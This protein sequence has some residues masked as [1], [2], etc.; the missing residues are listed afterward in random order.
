[1]AAYDL[2]LTNPKELVLD[3]NHAA[4]WRHSLLTTHM[5]IVMYIR[6]HS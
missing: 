6:N 5:R 4:H 2:Y 1:V 3:E